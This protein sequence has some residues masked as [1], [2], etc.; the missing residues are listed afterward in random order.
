MCE[1][2]I[3]RKKCLLVLFFSLDLFEMALRR[4]PPSTAIHNA[5]MMLVLMPDRSS[6]ADE[7]EQY[8]IEISVLASNCLWLWS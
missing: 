5:Q 7:V 2:V 6:I 8:V 4:A 1:G 3:Y